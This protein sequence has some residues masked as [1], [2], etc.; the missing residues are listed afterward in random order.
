MS[1][2][3]QKIVRR[4]AQKISRGGQKFS[5]GMVRKMSQRLKV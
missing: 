2:G 4:G 1:R 5:R 3:G